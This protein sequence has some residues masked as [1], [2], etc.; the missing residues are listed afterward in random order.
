MESA[1]S[2]IKPTVQ[3][4]V[5]RVPSLPDELNISNRRAEAVLHQIMA[6]CSPFVADFHHQSCGD[7]VLPYNPVC[8]SCLHGVKETVEHL[9]LRSA[10]SAVARRKHIGR[11][12]DK[13]V[14]E[15]CREKPLE[16]LR[17]LKNEKLLESNFKR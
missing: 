4:N 5:I 6:N 11:I 12:G 16:V 13:A 10:G 9:L 14:E 3:T 2:I 7:E 17:F 8:S 15:L 1:R